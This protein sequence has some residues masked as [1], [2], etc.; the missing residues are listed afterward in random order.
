[1]VVQQRLRAREE[2]AAMRRDR[3]EQFEEEA[4]RI[5]HQAA[6][7]LVEVQERLGSTSNSNDLEQAVPTVPVAIT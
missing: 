1:M 5:K 4:R 7:E 2:V 3:V 6:L